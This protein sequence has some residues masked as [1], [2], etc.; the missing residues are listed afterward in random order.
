MLR[1]FNTYGP[2]MH[3]NDGR[4]LSN[5]I[6]QALR[7]EN[8]SIYGDGTQTRSFCYVDDMVEAMIRMMKTPPGFSG[9]VNAGN[10]A[11]VSISELAEKIIEITGSSSRIDFM[12]LPD[13]P[14]R[15][16]PDITLAEEKLGWKPAVDLEIGLRKTVDYFRSMVSKLYLLT[17]YPCGCSQFIWF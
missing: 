8:I 9:P 1:I 16:K 6:L 11:E 13:D 12:K 5:F 3:P 10:P 2:R 15:R 7:C 17:L 4:A 14:R